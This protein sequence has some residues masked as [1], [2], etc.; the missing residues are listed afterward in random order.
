MLRDPVPAAGGAAGAGAD[1]CAFGWPVVTGAPWVGKLRAM[2]RT[3]RASPVN[4][5][6]LG[7]GGGAVVLGVVLG[8]AVLA[9]YPTLDPENVGRGFVLVGGLVTAILVSAGGQRVRSL[10][11]PSG[12]VRRVVRT[13]VV[14]GVISTI[15]GVVVVP[16]AHGGWTPVLVLTIVGSLALGALAV[17][18][19][20][21]VT[22]PSRGAAD[23]PPSQMSS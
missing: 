15:V 7:L 10:H 1:F 20:Q 11:R 2:T 16:L 3:V 17:V 4:R 14:Y 21:W 23:Q 6:A 5:Q 22:A 18:V 19:D 13:L 8:L 9:L 12:D